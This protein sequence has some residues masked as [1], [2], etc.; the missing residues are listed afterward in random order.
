[1]KGRPVKGGIVDIQ[2][3]AE[4][5]MAYLTIMAG[6]GNRVLY[7]VFSQ[8]DDATRKRII[9]AMAESMQQ[10]EPVM[11]QYGLGRDPE[12][13]ARGM[14]LTEDLIGCE[15]SGE[16]ASISDEEVVR[17]VT[18]C[19]WSTMFSTDGGTCRLVMAAM[20][21]GIG[22]KYGLEITCEQNMAE[23]AEHCIWKIRKNRAIHK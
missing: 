15:P 16:L 4:E 14:M 7:D 8:S 1:L 6:A 18:F 12:G 13:V 10:L 5:K 22:K 11:D 3:P 2:I 21:E 20:E 17:K 9:S 19:P 23:G